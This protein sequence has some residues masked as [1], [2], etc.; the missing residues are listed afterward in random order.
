MVYTISYWHE[1]GVPLSHRTLN[2]VSLEG[3]VATTTVV[4]DLTGKGVTV[5][6]DSA[7]I[8]ESVNSTRPVDGSDEEITEHYTVLRT[9]SLPDLKD[10]RTD[11]LVGNYTPIGVG[12][13]FLLLRCSGQSG[14]TV[15][16]LRE[17]AEGTTIGYY[18]VR[19]HFVKA[20][21]QGDVVYLVQGV[22]GV[23]GLQLPS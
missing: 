8:A 4:L 19:D 23:I 17:D 2:V 20:H 15:L 13:G 18:K 10:V 3:D 7:I 21:R 1:D 12:E 16:D 5:V 11:I 14:I 9:V 22:Y 6:G